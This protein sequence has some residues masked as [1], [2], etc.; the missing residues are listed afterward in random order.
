M[1]TSSSLLVVKVLPEE[2]D[3]KKMTLVMLVL[4]LPSLRGQQITNL[5]PTPQ[6]SYY[7]S[8]RPDERA[9]MD[10]IEARIRQFDPVVLGVPTHDKI[11]VLCV[12]GVNDGWTG[13]DG[14]FSIRHLSQVGLE[15]FRWVYI[16]ERAHEFL[17]KVGISSLL[18]GGAEFATWQYLQLAG[19]RE[20]F[21]FLEG[22]ARDAGTLEMSRLGTGSSFEGLN[23]GQAVF[24]LALLGFANASGHVSNWM[25]DGAVRKTW[26]ALREVESDAWN[27]RTRIRQLNAVAKKFPYPVDGVDSK[28]WLRGQRIH[29][30]ATGVDEEIIEAW[31]VGKNGFTAV[32]PEYLTLVHARIAAGRQEYLYSDP[33]RVTVMIMDW[34]GR[35]VLSKVL[36]TGDTLPLDL[37]QGAYTLE[38]WAEGNH[39]WHRNHFVRWRGDDSGLMTVI[40]TNSDGVVR[41]VPMGVWGGKSLHNS[42][43]FVVVDPKDKETRPCEISVLSL[44]GHEHFNCFPNRVVRLNNRK[45]VIDLPETVFVGGLEIKNLAPQAGGYVWS[46]SPIT[47]GAILDRWFGEGDGSISVD[48]EKNLL[49]TLLIFR[50]SK[51]YD[52]QYVVVE[53]KKEGHSPPPRGRK[54]QKEKLLLY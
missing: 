38:V 34:T 15:R 42:K 4:A 52:M 40:K 25:H 26:Q 39:L 29:Q 13:F 44:K 19:F 23:Y 47:P 27:S 50:A 37:P 30:Q 45:V 51:S 43:G 33:V 46:F 7:D 54:P 20:T 53:P 10:K 21:G 5:T 14:T 35:E 6:I 8:C 12:D 41:E 18:E 17:S 1:K 9:E 24:A 11:L 16:H 32:N 31:T 28:I 49:S 36:Q 3:M 2:G 48:I 22:V